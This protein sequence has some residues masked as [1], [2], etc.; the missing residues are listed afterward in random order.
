MTAQEHREKHKELHKALDELAADYMS[1]TEKLPSETTVMELM[2]WSHEQTQNA[3]A[4]PGEIEKY[5]CRACGY[6]TSKS[7]RC[8]ECSDC[9]WKRGKK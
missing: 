1:E 2:Q 8:P 3:K 9:D 4:V 7:L 6:Q 5:V